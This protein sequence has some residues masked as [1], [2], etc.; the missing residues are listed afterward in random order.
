MNMLSLLGNALLLLALLVSLHQIFRP[1]AGSDP[2]ARLAALATQVSPFVLLV[3]AFLIQAT[4]LEL[5]SEY[6]GEKLPLFYRI[7][8]VWGS[9][10]GPLMMWAAMVSVI[11]L[12]MDV[13]EDRVST[14]ARIM[15]SWTTILL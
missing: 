3:M 11:T 15:H 12:A 10:A 7:S 9:R 2:R 13:E 4:N 6:A 14:S 5:V 1:E 8:A